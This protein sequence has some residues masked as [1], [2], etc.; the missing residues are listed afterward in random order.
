[1]LEYY[2]LVIPW[3]VPSNQLHCL[4]VL[5]CCRL[6]FEFVFPYHKRDCMHSMHSMCSSHRLLQ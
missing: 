5:G 2:K 6:E 1:M 3:L 4:Q